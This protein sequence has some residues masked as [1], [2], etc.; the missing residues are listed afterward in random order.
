MN[1]KD[2]SGWLHRPSQILRP[3]FESVKRGFVWAAQLGSTLRGDALRNAF[4]DPKNA[5]VFEQ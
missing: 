1:Y 4:G 3:R 5:A 2:S